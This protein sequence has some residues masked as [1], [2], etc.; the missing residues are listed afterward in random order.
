MSRLC[1]IDS[2]A[3]KSSDFSKKFISKIFNSFNQLIFSTIYRNDQLLGATLFEL[4]RKKGSMNVSYTISDPNNL[5]SEYK[6]SGFGSILKYKGIRYAKEEYPELKEI[7]SYAG[8]IPS[9]KINLNL[10]FIR[11]VD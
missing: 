1:E 4:D 10:G 3:Y 8:T 9:G 2:L 11:V 7:T 5:I 6:I